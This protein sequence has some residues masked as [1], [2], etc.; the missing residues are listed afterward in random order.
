MASAESHGIDAD[1]E[2]YDISEFHLNKNNNY[3]VHMDKPGSSKVYTN[4]GRDH[5]EQLLQK[6]GQ[7]NQLTLLNKIPREEAVPEH[8]SLEQALEEGFRIS[9]YKARSPEDTDHYVVHVSKGDMSK[10]YSNIKREHLAE[11][12]NC[13]ETDIQEFY[14][15]PISEDQ[16]KDVQ[17]DVEPSTPSGPS[18]R[19]G[20]G[21]PKHFDEAMDHGFEIIEYTQHEK[22]PNYTVTVKKNENVKKF[23]NIKAEKLSMY[24]D[25]EPSKLSSLKRSESSSPRRAA[26]QKTSSKL[27]NVD[28]L[29]Q[30]ANRGGKVAKVKKVIGN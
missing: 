12:L 2:Q 1:I 9:S 11:L 8:L 16:P 22:N 21:F 10:P 28:Q 3:V 23:T 13:D 6:R 27:S 17:M 18:M 20:Q 26:A 5:L 15:F 4:I 14:E 25:V 24:M 29:T 7:S 30:C 19:Q